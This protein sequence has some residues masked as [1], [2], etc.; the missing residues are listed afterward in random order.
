MTKIHLDDFKKAEDALS[1]IYIEN[2]L[3][4]VPAWEDFINGIN[5]KYKN[6]NG[7][8]NPL[9]DVYVKNN[10]QQTDIAFTN[11]NHLDPQ[12]HSAVTSDMQTNLFPQTEPLL[13]MVSDLI[14]NKRWHIKALMNFAGTGSEHEYAAHKDDHHVVSWQCIGK[15]EYRIYNSKDVDA[16]F[17]QP[18]DHLVGEYKSYILNPGDVIYL[19]SGLIHKV[20]TI[21][22]RA[23]LILDLIN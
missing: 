18:V 14:E 3:P 19:P 5:Y 20:V 6:P 10:G 13:K 12:Y 17:G 2:V 8:G 15:V 11:S 21:E 23:T 22:P 16:K 7:I 4:S 9:V 1:C